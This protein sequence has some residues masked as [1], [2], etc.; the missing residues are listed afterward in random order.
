[1]NNPERDRSKGLGLGL[2]IVQ[3]ICSLLDISL[4]L[5]S[6]INRGSIFA[7]SIERGD[8]SLLTQQTESD[9]DYSAV[10]HLFV[11]I[12]DD[13]ED[14]RLS[15]EGLL[16]AW[17]CEVMV[18]GSGEEAVEQL[19]EYD[20]VP[21][22]VIS[23]YRLRNNETGSDALAQ[24]RAYCGEELPGI[25]VTGDIAPERLIEI[26]RLDVPVLHKPCSPERLRMLLQNIS[27]SG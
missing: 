17:G 21:D 24:I 15:L 6:I 3:R 12:I 2:S 16:C 26:D 14:V 9:I 25:I 23:D 7:I 13:E 1:L 8:V 18:A 5:E 11:L 10:Q 27:L 22:V 4:S 20:S 19:A